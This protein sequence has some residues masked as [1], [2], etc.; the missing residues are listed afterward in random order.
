[1]TAP[2]E[3]AGRRRVHRAPALRRRAALLRAAVE[4]IGERGVGAVTHRAVAARAGIP[5]ANTTYFFSSIEELVEE[6]LSTWVRERGAELEALASHALAEHSG[7][8]A[9]ADAFTELLFTGIDASAEQAQ[10]EAYLHAA[11]NPALRDVVHQAQLSFE[12]VAAVA[13]RA[14]GATRPE[15]G[16]RAFAALTDGFMIQQLADP[17]ADTAHSFREAAR[18]LF[19]AFAMS[20][21]ERAA[22]D[23]RVYGGSEPDRRG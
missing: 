22:W 9:I 3:P 19:I 8:G 10:Y 11:R 15:R 5:V 17:R 23:D 16:A 21:E 7:A 1:M 2:P 4:I 13:L 20:D 18:A 6:A 14:A 12:R